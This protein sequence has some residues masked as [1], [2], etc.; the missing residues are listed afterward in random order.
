MAGDIPDIDPGDGGGVDETATKKPAPRLAPTG[1]RC[2][3]CDA[4]IVG[5]YCAVCGQK[6]D[7]MR[8]S[9]F[10][11]FRDF[12][13]DTFAF[14][15]RMWSTLALMASRPGHVPTHY[16]HGRRSRYT[17]PVRLFLVVSFLFFLALGLTRTMFIAMEVTAKT[18]EEIARDNTEFEEA[19]AG[20]DDE[21]R[22]RVESAR[23]AD[24]AVVIDG[25][26]V[27]CDINVSARFFVRPQDVRIDEDKW[28]A[29][30]QSVTA[31]ANVEIDKPENN[32]SGAAGGP[33]VTT[34]D[35]RNGLDRVVGGLDVF[36]SDPQRLNE[37]I[38]TWLPRVMF[39]MAP[40]LALLLGL[41]IRG[42]DALF[43]DHLVLSLYSHATGFAVFGAAIIL[44]Q[45][46]VP[47]IFPVAVAA[48]GVYFILALK[49]AYGRGWIKTVWTFLAGSLLYLIILVSIVSAIIANGIWT[50]AA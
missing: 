10:L 22:A 39:F 35:I 5:P 17:P 26:N 48:L 27:D 31:A 18:P 11:L 44:G 45:F 37:S 7:D 14:D 24:G 20:M 41:F 13:E 46:G 16:S 42:R 28:R 3:S 4:E 29:C 19:L 8:R 23:K 1:D 50:A 9:S 25:E 36:V 33:G 15:S 21:T 43:F 40:V 12:I 34:D 32:A 2:L 38:N 6:N 47:Q 49:R 30:A